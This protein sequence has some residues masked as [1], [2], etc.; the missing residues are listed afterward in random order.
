MKGAV[1]M[2]SIIKMGPNKE[3]TRNDPAGNSPAQAGAGEM[4]SSGFSI[5][6]ATITE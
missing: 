3:R 5:S 1:V 4:T 2:H 6:T